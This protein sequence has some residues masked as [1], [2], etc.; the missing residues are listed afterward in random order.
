MTSWV[1]LTSSSDQDPLAQP[2][3]NQLSDAQYFSML[4]RVSLIIFSQ[5]A[6]WRLDSGALNLFETMHPM[7][8]FMSRRFAGSVR[9]PLINHGNLAQQAQHVLRV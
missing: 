9:E 7:L 5:A 3:P 2:I 6:I 1:K 4:G 8:R